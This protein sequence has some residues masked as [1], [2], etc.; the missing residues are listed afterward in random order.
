MDFGLTEEQRRVHMDIQ[1]NILAVEL[2]DAKQFETLEGTSNIHIQ[3][4]ANI[5]LGY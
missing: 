3:I 2:R 1:P 4:I 5:E